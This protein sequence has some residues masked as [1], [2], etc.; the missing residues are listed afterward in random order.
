MDF[1]MFT[2]YNPEES[3]MDKC[4]IISDDDRSQFDLRIYRISPI[5]K[6]P[7]N[8]PFEILLDI[9][10]DSNR[11]WRRKRRNKVSISK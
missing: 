1:R 5:K 6:I 10:R 2:T 3:L 4:G 9:L 11:R 8:H 7:S